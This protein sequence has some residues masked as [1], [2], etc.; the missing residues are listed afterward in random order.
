M[1]VYYSC[2][3]NAQQNQHLSRRTALIQQNAKQVYRTKHNTRFS[4]GILSSPIWVP[5]ERR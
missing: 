4:T 5:I 3:H 2:S 1:F